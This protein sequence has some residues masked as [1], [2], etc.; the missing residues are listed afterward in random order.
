ML[1]QVKKKT[2][3]DKK[4]EEQSIQGEGLDNEDDVVSEEEPMVEVD[5]VVSAI[6]T[7]EDN[8]LKPPEKPILPPYNYKELKT[9]HY[10][11]FLTSCLFTPEQQLVMCTTGVLVSKD[12]ESRKIEAENLSLPSIL[13]FFTFYYFFR[14]CLLDVCY[15]TLG[16]IPTL[17]ILLPLTI[18]GIFVVVVIIGAVKT[19]VFG[20]KFVVFRLII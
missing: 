5:D 18:E 9:I 1:K 11:K 4:V 20:S 13:K 2:K 14:M 3:D 10:A 19:N 17:Q 16:D 15:L 7:D 8:Q 6:E 12:K